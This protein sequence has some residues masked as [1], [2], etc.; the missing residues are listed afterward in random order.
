MSWV[1]YLDISECT[2]KDL[3]RAYA[4]HPISAI[5]FDYS[6]LMLRIEDPKVGILQAAR[7][8]G[9]TVVAFSPLA[10]GLIINLQMILLQMTSA[11]QFLDTEN[12]P[13]VLEASN[14]IKAIGA[15]HNA[16]PGQATLAWIWRRPE[17]VVILH[18]E[19][20]Y[21]FCQS[22]A[23]EPFVDCK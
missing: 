21:L 18:K 8:L 10:K 12:F 19:I 20:K 9:I 4:V 17:F 23:D 6:P 14:R 11:G 5:Q 16:T 7:E 3:R 13:K 22:L 2:A 1:K 15:A